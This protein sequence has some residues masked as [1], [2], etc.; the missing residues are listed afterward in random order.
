[1]AQTGPVHAGDALIRTALLRW[2]SACLIQDG[3]PQYQRTGR[4]LF[5]EVLALSQVLRE[6]FQPGH[7]RNPSAILYPALLRNGP[8]YII[9]WLSVCVAGGVFVPLN[10]RWTGREC[11]DA[12]ETVGAP[13][14]I[15]DHASAPLA[16]AAAAA[17]S[18]TRIPLIPL[19]TLLAKAALLRGKHATTLLYGLP[20]PPPESTLRALLDLRWAHLGVALVCFTSGTTGKAKAAAIS[21]E[22]IV[23]QS[24]QKL[25]YVHYSSTDVYL[26]T[27]PLFHI[28]GASSCHANLFAGAVHV[29]PDPAA[30]ATP[31][32]TLDIMQRHAVTSMISVPAMIVDLLR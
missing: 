30:P 6:E 23:F 28:G 8:D 13:F 22:A 3:T 9:F 20:S 29:F 10:W 26:H 19:T 1:M 16:L 21:H 24:L 17:S 12:L 4:Q 14:L 7:L 15:H 18:S 5:E 32:T 31:A 11:L 27:A 25:R 2:D